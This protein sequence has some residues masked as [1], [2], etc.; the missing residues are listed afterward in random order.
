MLISAQGHDA[1]DHLQEK[2]TDALV[3]AK[4]DDVIVVRSTTPD[5][6]QSSDEEVHLLGLEYLEGLSKSR[7]M[8]DAPLA[9]KDKVTALRNAAQQSTRYRVSQEERSGLHA[10]SSLLL[11]ALISSSP[12]R[13]HQISKDWWK[14]AS[15]SIGLRSRESNRSGVGWPANVIWAPLVIGDHNQLAPFALS[16]S[17]RF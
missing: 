5:R 6:R 11:D 7:L 9:L 3:E 1:L 13:I 4:L 14:R 8:D 17:R 2:I 12:R 15:S 10:I 16:G